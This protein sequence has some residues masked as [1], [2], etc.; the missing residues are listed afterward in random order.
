MKKFKTRRDFHEFTK[1]TRSI[2]QAICNALEI[3]NRA[4]NEAKH[5]YDG[6]KGNKP[7]WATRIWDPLKKALEVALE[8]VY[9]VRLV[10]LDIL[11]GNNGSFW[12]DIKEALAE[13]LV[14][15]GNEQ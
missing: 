7:E 10:D 9:E 11:W 13:A 3:A 1:S 6:E 8:D 12:F 2:F 4:D 14:E 15:E 5:E